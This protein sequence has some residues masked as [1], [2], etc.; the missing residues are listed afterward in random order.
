MFL[1][2]QKSAKL[3]RRPLQ[4]CSLRV[5]CLALSGR[6]AREDGKSSRGEGGFAFLPLPALGSVLDLKALDPGLA[7]ETAKSGGLVFVTARGGSRRR[8]VGVGCVHVELK[9]H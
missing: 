6:A 5:C 9:D 8:R 2:D 1:P 7:R 3:E 4:I